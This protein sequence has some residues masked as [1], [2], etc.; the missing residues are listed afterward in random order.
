M[1]ATATAPAPAPTPAATPTPAAPAPP[2]AP[3]RT[4]VARTA[5]A[6]LDALAA[7]DTEA[8]VAASSARFSFDGDTR[9]GREAIR[10]AWHGLLARRDAPRSAVL[11][12][13]VLP[14][15]EA[16]ARLGPP[17]VRIAPLAK[18]GWV[19][20]GNVSGRPVILFLV[21]EDGR[22]AVAGIHG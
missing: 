13:E 5:L 4:Q 9:T 17:P 7:G 21:R 12:L 20:I 8:L 11:D 19:A 10:A 18:A 22:W 16:V 3:E 2:P 14:A 15:A 6:F 1:P